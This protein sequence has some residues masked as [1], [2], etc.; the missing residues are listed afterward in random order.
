MAIGPA[1]ATLKGGCKARR[2]AARRLA[3]P[4]DAQGAA[5]AVRTVGCGAGRTHLTATHQPS[6]GGSAGELVATTL[7]EARLTAVSAVEARSCVRRPMVQPGPLILRTGVRQRRRAV[8]LTCVLHLATPVD[9]GGVGAREVGAATARHYDPCQAKRA[10]GDW[11][12]I[13]PGPP[14]VTAPEP[15]RGCGRA[16]RCRAARS[17]P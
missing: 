14:H 5:T 2:G 13:C 11:R 16:R 9:P 12:S 3:T 1:F 15:A 7:D 10:S 6:S 4:A 17:M 8:P